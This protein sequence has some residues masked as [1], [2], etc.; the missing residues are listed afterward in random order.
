[1]SNESIFTKIDAAGKKLGLSTYD[2]AVLLQVT[3]AM[4]SRYRHGKVEKIGSRDKGKFKRA[5]A[6]MKVLAKDRDSLASAK[7]RDRLES[8]VAAMQSV[9]DEPEVIKVPMFL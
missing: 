7:P 6:A 3:P 9:V 4:V 5:A 8:V 2:M 1:M